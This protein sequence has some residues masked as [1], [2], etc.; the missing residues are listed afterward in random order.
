L[1]KAIIKIPAIPDASVMV[2][3]LPPSKGDF[4]AEPGRKPFIKTTALP[5]AIGVYHP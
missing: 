3:P 4:L 1:V 2:I 5:K